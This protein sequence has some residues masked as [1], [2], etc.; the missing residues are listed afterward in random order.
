MRPPVSV[1]GCR[2]VSLCHVAEH[3]GVA[4]CWK[5]YVATKVGPVMSISFAVA[6]AMLSISSVLSITVSEDENEQEAE[7]TEDLS[8]SELA[9]PTD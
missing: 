7:A 6:G 5:R 3:G 2:C 4:S 1:S 9:T 8:D